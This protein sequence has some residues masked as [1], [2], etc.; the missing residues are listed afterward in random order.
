MAPERI[1][2][3][4]QQ[5]KWVLDHYA[6]YLFAAPLVA[7]RRVLDI[8]CGLGYGS[9]LLAQAGAQ[10]VIGVDISPEAIAYARE[11]YAH[12][13][14]LFECKDI[15]AL[16]IDTDGRFDVIVCFE[17]LEHVP[18]VERSLDVLAGLLDKQGSLV[19]SIPNDL[20]LNVD[21][22]YHLTRF[23]Q[24]QFL[25]LLRARFKVVM[26]YYQNDL[27]ASMVW[28]LDSAGEATESAT[29]LPMVPIQASIFNYGSA[30]EDARHADCFLAICGNET[31]QSLPT[32]I[33]QSGLIWR[34]HNQALRAYID[35]LQQDR[36]RLWAEIEQ[37]K[38]LF[39]ERDRNWQAYTQELIDQRQQLL[40]ELQQLQ[41]APA[42]RERQ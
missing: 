19:I 24:D 20:G 7:G 11:H 36:D 28:R 12:E 31:V 32:V 9:H 41:Q 14:V 3:A 6:R 29:D 35:E 25:D 8:A 39:E 5:D 23:T 16:N 15:V 26:P 22:P 34:A 33:V 18:E 10:A 13:R 2:P 38:Q 21:N 1:D 30:S 27:A 37:L 4:K 42:G 17:T 40:A